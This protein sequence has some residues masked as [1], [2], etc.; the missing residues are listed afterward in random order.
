MS[1]LLCFAAM[2]AQMKAAIRSVGKILAHSSVPPRSRMPP[3]KPIDLPAVVLDGFLHLGRVTF[4]DHVIQ[5]LQHRSCTAV[6]RDLCK[7]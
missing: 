7:H 3:P 5:D 6:E 1:L 4:R 2:A